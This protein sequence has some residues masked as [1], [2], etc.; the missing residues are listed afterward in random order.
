ME[1]SVLKAPGAV[2]GGPATGTRHCQAR[3]QG[4]L[5]PSRH[6]ADARR[7]RRPSGIITTRGASPVG[8]A[9]TTISGMTAGAEVSVTRYSSGLMRLAAF[10]LMQPAVTASA[11]ARKPAAMLILS[12]FTTTSCDTVTSQYSSF[13]SRNRPSSVSNPSGARHALPASCSRFASSVFQPSGMTSNNGVS[14][15]LT[16][17]EPPNLLGDVLG[18]AA[19]P[20]HQADPGQSQFIQTTA[21][22]LNRK[23]WIPAPDRLPDPGAVALQKDWTYSR[24]S[25]MTF[26]QSPFQKSW[27]TSF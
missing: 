18:V 16:L 27:P 9:V 17:Q 11:A 3:L 6:P 25:I 21:A 7:S 8:S 26:S 10:S 13:Q 1:R 12:S 15:S 4:R 22:G 24:Q 14:S 19:G 23:V 2:P 20:D 5:E